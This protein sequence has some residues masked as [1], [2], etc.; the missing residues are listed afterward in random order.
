MELRTLHKIWAIR[1][2]HAYYQDCG[3]HEDDIL[4]WRLEPLDE[5]ICLMTND[6]GI[7][8]YSYVNGELRGH[9]EIINKDGCKELYKL[10]TKEESFHVIQKDHDWD[11][12]KNK[13][14]FPKP[15]EN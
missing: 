7:S 5:N 8:I 15:P 4:D 3:C 10:L 12:K 2:A 14:I 13:E 11:F 6:E 1:F 9:E